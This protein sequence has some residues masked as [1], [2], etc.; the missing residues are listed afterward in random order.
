M[1]SIA[2]DILHSI[3]ALSIDDYS[4]V[5]YL[6]LVCKRWYHVTRSQ[7]FWKEIEN[8]TNRRI[9]YDNDM[10]VI[11]KNYDSRWL[12]PFDHYVMYSKDDKIFFVS[13]DTKHKISV[14]LGHYDACYELA[15]I[16]DNLFHSTLLWLNDQRVI[17][18]TMLHLD[19]FKNTWVCPAR[20]GGK[21]MVYSFNDNTLKYAYVNDTGRQTS[22]ITVSHDN[23]YDP[24]M[25]HE[26]IFWRYKD[27]YRMRYT[28]ITSRNDYDI[29]DASRAINKTS[30][31]MILAAMNHYY[32]FD[33]RAGTILSK[34]PIPSN[35]PLVTIT[36]DFMCI[37]DNI[38][39]HL[40]T[41]KTLTESRNDGLKTICTLA[42][43]KGYRLFFR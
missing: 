14:S 2:E 6:R 17:Q 30:K 36:P 23:L 28:G 7:R 16:T 37:H 5:R 22:A 4:T 1:D 43:C 31:Y 26:G 25:G 11:V 8:N 24:H 13:N 40:L 20:I 21:L 38:Y 15:I 10:G 39:I 29:S 42:Y 34:I 12:T 32:L 33:E 9:R 27:R 41:G 3:L 35:Y 19:D 18:K